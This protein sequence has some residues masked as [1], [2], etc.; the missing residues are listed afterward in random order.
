MRVA[1]LA[2]L[3]T[4]LWPTPGERA[5]AAAWSVR[6]RWPPRAAVVE[7]QRLHVTVHFLGAVERARIAEI[8]ALLR[9]SRTA[10]PGRFTLRLDSPAV[11]RGGTVVLLPRDVPQA[12][13]A[14]HQAIGAELAAIGIA[15]DARHYRPHLTLARHA[16]GT[17]L[18]QDAPALH[19][20]PSRVVLV[21][22]VPGST[23]SY[24]VVTAA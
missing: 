7:P 16:A 8:L 9:R 1:D 14:L 21:E 15:C 4:A 3:F 2:R 22:S 24:R 6:C 23:P 19:W 11:W 17:R 13:A 10:A 5:A 12:L 18:P 20:R